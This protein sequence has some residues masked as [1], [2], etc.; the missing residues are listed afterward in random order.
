MDGQ[1]VVFAKNAIRA[2]PLVSLERADKREDI[3]FWWAGWS[4]LTQP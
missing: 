2:Y 1:L 4:G 3:H